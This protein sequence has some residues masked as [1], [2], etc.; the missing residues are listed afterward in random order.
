MNP[1]QFIKNKTDDVLR[2]HGASGTASEVEALHSI[3]NNINVQ[4]KNNY[5]QGNYRTNAQQNEGRL[6]PI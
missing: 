1:D 3:L 4:T 2:A 6:P 5:A